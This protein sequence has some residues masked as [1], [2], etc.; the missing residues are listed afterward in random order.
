MNTSILIWEASGNKTLEDYL[1]T[2]T[3]ITILNVIITEFSFSKGQRSEM[4]SVM[5]KQRATKAII[6]I[7]V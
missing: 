2:L 4:Y 7:K 5:D 6:I 1:Y 3:N